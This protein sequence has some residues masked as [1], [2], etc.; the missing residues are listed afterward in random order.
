MPIYT[1]PHL[2]CIRLVS[3]RLSLPCIG[4]GMRIEL[5]FLKSVVLPSSIRLPIVRKK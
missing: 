1:V 3:V 4:I 5:T 2:K